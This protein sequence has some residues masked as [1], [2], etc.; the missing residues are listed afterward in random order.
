LINIGLQIWG[1]SVLGGASSNVAFLLAAQSSLTPSIGSVSNVSCA[2]GYSTIDFKGNQVDGL[3]D[4][5]MFNGARRVENFVNVNPAHNTEDCTSYFVA[6]NGPGLIAVSHIE[7]DAVGSRAHATVSRP[8]VAGENVNLVFK[9]SGVGDIS[10]NLGR[11][12]GGAFEASAL[13]VTLST[14]PQRFSISHQ[15]SESHSVLRAQIRRSSS[16]DTA[17]FINVSEFMVYSGAD[18]AENVSS[19]VLL[20]P[21][22]GANVDGVKYFTSDESHLSLVDDVIIEGAITPIPGATLKGIQIGPESTNLFLNSYTPATQNIA[23]TAQE[24]TISIDDDS[25]GSI[26]LSGSSTGVVSAGGPLTITASAGT[27]TLTVAGLVNVAQVEEGYTQTNF[28]R[29]LNSSATRDK[30]TVE[31]NFP[32][33]LFNNFSIDFSLNIQDLVPEVIQY[34]IGI[35][36]STDYIIAQLL[37]NNKLR[38]RVRTGGTNYTIQTNSALSSNVNYNISLVY[39][40]GMSIILNG[41]IQSQTN[42]IA[43]DVPFVGQQKISLLSYFTDVLKTLGSIESLEINRL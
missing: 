42:P 43:L 26:T 11:Q 12:V 31:Y 15:F 23:T 22:H 3:P 36:G 16:L 33:G 21:Y 40:N 41:V 28:I 4:E 39:N 38:F 8:V 13:R 37:G 18:L 6:Q 1:G 19:G 14:T 29:T 34:V 35:G 2:S 32:A 17:T 7:L 27:L 5:V 9:L 10:L 24:Y 25:T 20:S 30:M